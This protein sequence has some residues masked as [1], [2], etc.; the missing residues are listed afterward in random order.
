ML[1]FIFVID[2]LDELCVYFV[3]KDEFYLAIFNHMDY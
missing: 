1:Y 2:C 3:F